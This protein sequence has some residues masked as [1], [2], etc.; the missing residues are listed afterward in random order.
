MARKDLNI[1]VGIILKDIDKELRNLDSQLRSFASRVTATGRDLSATISLPILAAAGASVK[2]AVD[3]DRLRKSLE[4]VTGSSEAAQQELDN[5]RKIAELPGI[6]FEQAT[7]ATLS[8]R[9]LGFEAEKT[10]DTITGVGKAIAISGGTESNFEGAIRQL[11]QIQAK[12]RVLQEDITILL[13]NMPVLGKVLQ[14]TFGASTA[15][16]IRKTGV[17]GGEFVDIL[18]KKLNELPPVQGG[19]ALAFENLGISAQFALAS[20]GEEVARVSN[21]EIVF[22]N[23]SN[24]LNRAADVFKALDDETKRSI[25]RFAGF[26]AALGPVLIISG[27]VFGA[28]NNIRNG[29]ALLSANITK[30]IAFLGRFTVAESQ[31]AAATTILSRSVKVLYASLGV[32][33]V[34]LIATQFVEWYQS[35][36]SATQ[37]LDEGKSSV[38]AYGDAI[39]EAEA[40]A[41]SQIK[42]IDALI[43]KIKNENESQDTRVAALRRLKEEYPGYF[44]NV[45]DDLTNIA[46]LK[47]GYDQL[48]TAILNSAKA[49]AA[50][51]KLQDLAGQ[52]LDLKDQAVKAEE[53]I[54]ASL[55]KIR[56]KGF[57]DAAELQRKVEFNRK[58]IG[59]SGNGAFFAQAKAAAELLANYERASSALEEIKTKEST[60]IEQQQKLADLAASY[61][62]TVEAT[63]SAFKPKDLKAQA[64]AEKSL[65]EINKTYNET[66]AKLEASEKATKLLGNST[67]ESLRKQIVLATGALEK[68]ISL[69]LDPASQ[70]STFLVTKIA[71]LKTQLSGLLDETQLP[72][73][74]VLNLFTGFDRFAES[75]QEAEKITKQSFSNIP[76]FF[77]ALQEQVDVEK[78][79]D[80]VEVEGILNSLKETFAEF[81]KETAESS[82]NDGF[83]EI[84]NTLSGMKELIAPLQEG[85]E[86]FFKTVFEGGKNA[87]GEFAKSF[88]KSI[89]QMIARLLA[90]IAAAAILAALINAIFPAGGLSSGSKFIDTIR[91]NGGILKYILGGIGI[92]GLASGGIVTS[93]TL[94]VAGEGKHSEAILPLPYLDSLLSKSN[95]FGRGEFVL[96][97]EDLVLALDRAQKKKNRFNGKF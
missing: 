75:L 26:A 38:N 7:K 67:A 81:G 37:A 64:D 62:G 54:Q 47:T 65:V 3:F 71:E 72:K 29:L 14:D 95:D 46:Q 40:D 33:I 61:K 30:S 43:A 86:T 21:L 22:K 49:R 66:K 11:S 58:N 79:E 45:R 74:D 90:A 20:I 55:L 23:I 6:S 19:L 70:Q 56:E 24:A 94:L 85:I 16:G 5:L 1:S 48:S 83:Q 53:D 78:F 32:G 10:R 2:A 80:A 41:S 15:E 82:L 27:R 84:S 17:S 63:P 52:E 44:D 57:K 92:P 97:G 9:G 77:S 76:D 35:I 87:L 28:F 89:A 39:K 4:T 88:A 93:P 42:V 8:L 12:G 13:E 31:A 34:L 60:L 36:K 69:G 91:G 96:R 59:A 25:V 50:S 68:M 18:I 51:G 73:I